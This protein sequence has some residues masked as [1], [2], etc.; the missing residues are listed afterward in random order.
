[1][2]IAQ[3]NLDHPPLPVDSDN[4]ISDLKSAINE[5]EKSLRERQEIENALIS[6]RLAVKRDHLTSMFNRVGI[7]EMLEREFARYLRSQEPFS[8]LMIDVDHFKNVNDS[9]GH[10]TGDEVL[11]QLSARIASMLR[12]EDVLGRFGGEEFL[13]IAS[14]CGMK[15]A[16]ILGERIRAKVAE[17]PIVQV[18]VVSVSIGISSPELGP[19]DTTALVHEADKALYRA[20]QRGRNRI[21]L[22]STE[23]SGGATSSKP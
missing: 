3:G 7:E 12:L 13:V 15:E 14:R 1:M 16:A 6:A 17:S 4:E 8:L 10:L 11:K 9:Y 20:K 2:S 23:L 18:I 22:A 5:M 19:R 21:E